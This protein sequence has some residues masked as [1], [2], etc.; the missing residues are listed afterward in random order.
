MPRYSGIFRKFL[1]S[2]LFI[3]IIPSL[4]GY[5]SYRTSIAV[6]QSMS[7]ENSVTE[8]QKSQET[9]ER[10]MAEVVSFTRQLALNQDLNVLMSEEV[11]KG[12][13]NVYGMWDLMK[14]V[15]PFSQTNDFLQ[16][17]FIYFSNY[18]VILSKGSTYRPKYYYEVSHF[19]N[20]S[21]EEWEELLN[22]THRSVIL[23]LQPVTSDGK[24][25][26]AISYMQSLPL[27]SFSGSSP[28]TVV[29]MIDEK[30]I[31]NLLSGW[32][33]R[34]GGWTYIRDAEGNPISLQGI[35]QS[36]VKEISSDPT[37]LQEEQSQYYK[38][39]LVITMQSKTNGWVYQAGIPKK[40]IMEN[41]NKI[42]Y[43][44]WFVTG[45]ALLLGLIAGL[46]LSYRNS[47]P[48]HKLLTVMKEQ[49]AKDGVPVRNEYD[50]LHGNISQMMMKNKRLETE[51][52]RQLP[53]IRDGFLKRLIM[54]EFQTVDE[55][56]AAATQAN[57]LF[58]SNMGYVAV[59]QINGY[60]GMDSVEVLNE[61]HA[62]R[63]ILTQ[64]LDNR[65]ESILLTDVGSDRIVMIY[66]NPDDEVIGDMGRSRMEQV[67]DHLFQMAYS[68]YKLKISVAVGDSFSTIQDI[69]HSYE[70]AKQTLEYAIL[71][72]RDY[73]VWFSD[74][75]VESGSYYY[76][77]DI[78][79][80]LISTIRAGDDQEAKRIV[81]SIMDKNIDNQ[82]LSVEMK[83]QLVS[84][85]RGTLIKL[86][87]QKV[88][89]ES[90]SF[91]E[92]HQQIMSIQ[93]TNEMASIKNEIEQIIQDLCRVIMR[94]KNHNHT[95]MIEQIKTYISSN[96]ADQELNLYRIA[97]QVE[98]PEKYISQIFKDVTGTN[99]SDYLEQVRMEVAVL[100]LTQKDYSVDEISSRTGYN[101]SHSFRR[102]FK[103]VMGVSPSSYRQ[104]M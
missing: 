32:T 46:L 95:R 93:P 91:D 47:A 49:F 11:V 71:N 33:E 59:L 57:T 55:I 70:Q 22:K 43:I 78:E 69:T 8:L 80:R 67:A 79:Q 94:K 62:A 99:V 82:H 86:I 41:A 2:Y 5:V 4:A 29:V 25:Y 53:L 12:K 72:N 66:M 19:K 28:A 50:F 54:G 103:R 48:L 101:S 9:L 7:I 84:E 44:S 21:W 15:T 104:S 1:I 10:R 60:T 68:E 26:A 73:I 74:S 76:P 58:P 27:D 90:A 20:M 64:M 87:N 17:Y 51:L 63:L 40:V 13:M 96:F 6:T 65:K 75:K 3:L 89:A 56:V 30:N 34:Y 39:D 61:L 38:D 102:A 85:I 77:M 88:F 24:E 31:S 36:E 81:K 98:R 35:S 18:N 83:L 52:T 45:I 16:N 100:L 42:K 97:E 92:L 23:P 14:Q 37:F